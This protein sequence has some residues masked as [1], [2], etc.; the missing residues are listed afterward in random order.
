MNNHTQTEKLEQLL[1]TLRNIPGGQAF[2]LVSK[3]YPRSNDLDF[4]S[5]YTEEVQRFSVTDV[6]RVT[7]ERDIDDFRVILRG[8]R[9]LIG[10]DQDPAQ[11]V[12]EM[13]FTAGIATEWGCRAHNGSAQDNNGEFAVELFP[14]SGCCY[15]SES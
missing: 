9:T 5:T 7:L 14:D 15:L 1:T 11:A 6:S 3:K 8:K 10:Q 13:L 2:D 4:L 12:S